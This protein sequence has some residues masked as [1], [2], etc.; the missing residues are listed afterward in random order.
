MRDLLPDA[1]T[2]TTT[3]SG[4][5]TCLDYPGSIR[6]QLRTET[7]EKIYRFCF[8]DGVLVDKQAFEE[9]P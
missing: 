8:R 6:E 9:T 1:E 3:R 7:G 4:G 5:A 2:A